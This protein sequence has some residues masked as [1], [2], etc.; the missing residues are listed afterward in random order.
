MGGVKIFSDT[1]QKY[2]MAGL[3]VSL[4]VFLFMSMALYS[5]LIPDTLGWGTVELEAS[6]GLLRLSFVLVSINAALVINSLFQIW[7]DKTVG[8][9]WA[10]Y[11]ET[12]WLTARKALYLELSLQ[13]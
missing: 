3:W 1:V 5:A 13:V 6:F 8:G 2:I 11:L 12:P 4:W 10:D 7:D 9:L